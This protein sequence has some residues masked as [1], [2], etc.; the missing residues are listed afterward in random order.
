MPS[1]PFR[2]SK[3]SSISPVQR[4]NSDPTVA[5]TAPPNSNESGEKGFPQQRSETSHDEDVPGS[6]PTLTSPA[7]GEGKTAVVGNAFSGREAEAH[8]DAFAAAKA[9]LGDEA[10]TAIPPTARSNSDADANSGT[11]DIRGAQEP[12]KMGKLRF[13][14][15]FVSQMLSIFLFALDQ[16]IIAT[17]IPRI[18]AEFQSLTEISWIINGFFITMLAFNLAYSQW[19]GILPSKVVVLWAVFIFEMGSLVSG[20]AKDM[21]VLIFGRALAGLGAAG[22]FSGNLVI[23]AEITTMSQRAK[24]MGLF[25]VK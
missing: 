11:H 21:N 15:I 2:R 23:L 4:L 1:F 14:L 13:C 10:G 8:P 12:I 24:M 5:K 7:P 3:G 6:T 25:G 16:L 20:V 17:A 18:T 22:L 9:G 19:L